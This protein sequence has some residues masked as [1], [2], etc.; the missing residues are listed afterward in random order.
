[1]GEVGGY[2]GPGM[3]GPGV[4]G[5]HC[6]IIVYGK[7]GS[8]GMFKRERAGTSSSS[9][10]FTYISAVKDVLEKVG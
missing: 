1:M 10:A 3:R 7:A 4:E 2:L 9:F 6:E 5:L 8:M